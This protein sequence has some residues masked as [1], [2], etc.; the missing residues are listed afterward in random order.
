LPATAT[1]GPQG[2]ID[3]VFDL[4]TAT[5]GAGE[6]FN[7]VVSRAFAVTGITGICKGANAN[8]NATV[9]RA[10]AAIGVVALT[11]LDAVSQAPTLDVANVNFAV[12]DT[13]RVVVNNAGGF[14]AVVVQTAPRP[15][16]DQT[17]LTG[18]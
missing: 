11:T 10:G 5:V 3:I 7:L 9:S 6:T 18:T 1:T 8:T 4:N 2:R 12:G 16:A 14:G 13:L 15:L 17:T